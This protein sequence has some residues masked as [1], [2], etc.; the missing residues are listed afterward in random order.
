MNHLFL[1]VRYGILT[2]G[3]DVANTGKL[4]II[5]A[6]EITIDEHNRCKHSIFRLDTHVP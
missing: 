3:Q 5:C 6:K 2:I 4:R 1:L